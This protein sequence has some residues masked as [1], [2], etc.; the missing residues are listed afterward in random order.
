MSLDP[1]KLADPVQRRLYRALA[2]RSFLGES[3][4]AMVDWAAEALS[5]G[6]DTDPLRILAGLGKPPNEFEVGRVLGEAMKSLGIEMPDTDDLVS[7]AAFIVASDLVS[8]TTPPRVGC[9]ELSRLCSATGYREN[10]MPFYTAEEAYS[11]AENGVYGTAQDVTAAVLDDARR[12][13]ESFT[14]R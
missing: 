14:L 12:L 11:L 3:G 5:A 8:G 10:L 9:E 1:T 7:T 4:G 6:W 2:R 13:V